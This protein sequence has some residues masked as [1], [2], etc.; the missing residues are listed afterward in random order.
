M[1]D[2]LLSDDEVFGN[3]LL[4]DDDLF[5]KPGNTV[6]DKPA[7][8]SMRADPM[9]DPAFVEKQRAAYAAIPE[10][11]RLPILQE[12]AKRNDVQGR[13][14][15]VILS[16]VLLENEAGRRAEQNQPTMAG[17]LAAAPRGAPKAS[18]SGR[19][20]PVAMP[21][22]KPFVTEIGS[23]PTQDET[24]AKRDAGLSISSADSS[25]EAM[26][27][28]AEMSARNFESEYFAKKNPMLA[29]L[30]SGGGQQ[31]AGLMNS[32]PT[33]LDYAGKMFGIQTR[34]PDSDAA[35][36]LL[37][38]SKSLMP[39]VGRQEMSKAWSKG[40]FGA[41]LA[42]NL[43]AQAP[44]VAG[45]VLSAFVPALRPFV[46][47]MMGAQQAGQS[48]AE[49]D[50]SMGA[51]L[52]GGAEIL[53]EMLPLKFFDKAQEALSKL[54]P[55]MRGEFLASLGKSLALRAGAITGQHIVGAIEEGTTQIL[56]NGVDRY[57]EG[58][59]TGLMDQVA[60]AAVLG[61][62][63]E[64]PLSVPHAL[65]GALPQS[66]GQLLAGALNADMADRSYTQA[67]IR[68]AALGRLDTSQGNIDPRLTVKPKAPRVEDQPTTPMSP[69][70][71]R[72]MAASAPVKA[73]VVADGPKEPAPAPIQPLGVAN[74]GQGS[75]ADIAEAHLN[76]ATDGSARPAVAPDLAPAGNEG[77]SG[78]PGRGPA[79]QLGAPD[80]NG[81]L[82]Q[83]ADESLSGGREAGPLGG[84]NKSDPALN[85]ESGV[86]AFKSAGQALTFAAQNRIAHRS[87]VQPAADGKG[88]VL[89]PA[90]KPTTRATI[91]EDADEIARTNAAV[92]RLGWK[93]DD[94]SAYSLV[95]VRDDAAPPLF[96]SVQ[97]V[98]ESA[99]GIRVLPV[100]GITSEG[101][102]AG[103]RAYVNVAKATS[104]GL[105]IGLTGHESFHWLEVNDPQAA[106]KLLKGLTPH[107][108]SGVLGA[109]ARKE[110]AALLPG[111]KP[112]TNEKVKSEVLAD[113]NGSMWVD[114][115][116]WGRMY[117]LDNGSTM[118]K[119]MYQFMRGAAK[120]VRLATGSR[121][122]ASQYV[123]DVAAVREV[124]A[125]VWSERVVTRAKS[126]GQSKSSASNKEA[127]HGDQEGQGQ[128]GLLKRR[129][130]ET[131]KEFAK[132]VVDKRE[133]PTTLVE[134]PSLY[135]T[136]PDGTID[137]KVSDLVSTKTDEE[138]QSGADNGAK[139]MAAA[140]AGE[141]SKR[142]PITVAL[143]KTSPGKYDVVDGNATFTTAKR[144]GWDSLPVMV[145]D[146]A[147]ADKMIAATK[148]ESKI[149]KV[150]AAAEPYVDKKILK[151][152]VDTALGFEEPPKPKI[153][154]DELLQAQR[155]M[156][157][158]MERAAEVNDDFADQVRAL[159]SKLG[160]KPKIGPLKKIDRA[161]EK[162]WEDTI[163]Q[164]KMPSEDAVKDL[165]RASIVVDSEADVPAA[166]EAAKAQ[167][168]V[169]DGR[170]KD[171]FK[172]PLPSGYRDILMNVRLENGTIAELQIHIPSMFE[173][174]DLG[175]EVYTIER[176]LPPG[177]LKAKLEDLQ[178]RYYNS[179]YAFSEGRASQSDISD[180]NSSREAGAPDS[181]A[182]PPENG[183]PV[184]AYTKEPSG[185]RSTG[186]PSTST[187]ITPGL[188]ASAFQS[189]VSTGTSGD[190]YTD[191]ESLRQA[192]TEKVKKSAAKP[193]VNAEIAP[194]PD[195]ANADRWRQM[196]PLERERVTRT[197]A[198]RYVPRVLEMVGLKGS[199]EFVQG[200][201]EG[202]TNPAILVRVTSGLLKER[203]Y[204]ALL[205][206]AK[207]VGRFLDQ[208]ATIAYDENVT[209]GEGLSYFVK[210]T[211]DRILTPQE[212]EG[213]FS[214]VYAQFSS[215]AGF[216][217]RDGALVFGNFSDLSP[218]DFRAGLESAIAAHP[219]DFGVTVSD[220]TFR[221]DYID[222]SQYG[223]NLEPGQA[224]PG[225][226]HV[227]RWSGDLDALQ[228]RFREDL[229]R[230]LVAVGQAR[231]RRDSTGLR[232]GTEDLAK[233][234]IAPGSTRVTVRRL[235]EA[236]NAR[237]QDVGAFSPYDTSP[238]AREAMAQSMADE[239]A[240]Q[241]END[242]GAETGTGV[243]WY[244]VNWPAA[245]IK[246][247]KFYPELRTSKDARSLFTALIAITSNGEKV[248]QNLA[249]AMRLYEG[250][251]H[252]G[253]TFLEVGIGT[254]QQESLDKNLAAFQDLISRMGV[255]RASEY[256]LE[257]LLVGDIKRQLAASGEDFNSGYKVDQK[258]P[259]SAMIFGPKLGAFFA[260]LMGRDGYLTMDLW[261]SRT[262][263]R[264]RGDLLPQATVK[265]LANIKRLLG[266]PEM[267]DEQAI[268]LA[269]PYRD[270]YAKR[271][272]K[273]GSE[274]EKAANTLMKAAEDEINEAPN[275]A[276]DRE[277]MVSSAQ[278]AR[279]IL[280]GR[281]IDITVADLQA[282]LWYYEKRLYAELGAKASDAIGYE[283]AIDEVT[284]KGGRE[285][286]SEAA[287]EV[288][289]PRQARSSSPTGEESTG[290]VD[291]FSN[292]Y[293]A[294][295]G[296]KVSFQ[297]RI[298]DTGQIANFTVDAAQY[299]RDIDERKD[300]ARQLAACI[301]R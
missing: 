38:T 45:S 113:I 185:E 280:A 249:M 208:K 245:I 117:E 236:L 169:I 14:A 154:A 267:T 162:L 276:S 260:N 150:A 250:Y 270:A 257:E 41:W 192:R 6:L 98:V 286:R 211:P 125:K 289:D 188:D 5:G 195:T 43:A 293:S 130:G 133:A 243:G 22:A 177:D 141:L 226:Q 240:F 151:E 199:L 191:S 3:K 86:D 24:L 122:D 160:A 84:V 18:G 168:D 87:T 148:R 287:R 262:F 27:S 139:R 244:S 72:A 35:Q 205:D 157:P 56:Q 54:P 213:V 203:G 285:A 23:M 66:K 55:T 290:I 140:A 173:S 212:V 165:V 8:A 183:L 223:Q 288:F 198:D 194:N 57:L 144:M 10:A 25:P 83:A 142:P 74:V 121:F 32:V 292:G 274:I 273:A 281:G 219:G 237:A 230:E 234:G 259:R 298:E 138:N 65:R 283:E 297:V 132:R 254:K 201:F 253:K 295:E 202:E 261:W 1:A 186:T 269:K 209:S 118:R 246:L 46:L 294:L 110:N 21:D 207:V 76:K 229:Q 155:F 263:N 146:R 266:N 75:L 127:N 33:I 7:P 238:E 225:G 68:D 221:S 296:R 216:T 235:A 255:R 44:Q 53:G 220:R 62:F 31:I 95:Q 232:A 172:K 299:L 189:N 271:G 176:A 277:F 175:H 252:D 217:A 187:N 114:P 180:S 93:N 184:R 80:G 69:E 91:K 284:R 131:E 48:F 52:K 272:F 239:V 71:L 104:P 227:R 204:D 126:A 29:A 222:E 73:P 2:A 182:R 164:G 67:G 58:K 275:N 15:K 128:E 134:D 19:Q 107:I 190:A 137:A 282:A 13:A 100:S 265:G 174:K 36:E 210:L 34:A 215:A 120:V 171:R 47:P 170:L 77:Q 90:V 193:G 152:M 60:D 200:G 145:V 88:W 81:R 156:G 256:L 233:Y 124:A 85:V 115:Q 242:A 119:V 4:S 206:A 268:D 63:M 78:Q 51:V 26:A 167:F 153:P 70:Q 214:S 94:G 79:D 136:S 96:R 99:F 101:L 89:V 181:R 251:V 147:A 178:A 159:A 228:A 39:E 279:Q 179:A 278:R 163:S 247:A 42:T 9:L 123:A 106:D 97:R 112:L 50:S 158:I 301:A 59:N 129:D 16:D 218:E 135:F 20:A 30:A 291:P 197:L 61:A 109:R 82:G 248:R 264:L 103:R 108:K 224:D 111:E 28:R 166:I 102:Q 143:S 64:G 17:A 12:A 161:A 241:L 149:K 116:F 11:D 105:I 231:P 196:S 49:G 37:R 258:L 92:Q 40:Q 300:I